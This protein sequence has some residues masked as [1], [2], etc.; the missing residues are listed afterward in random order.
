MIGRICQGLVAAGLVLLS[1]ITIESYARWMGDYRHNEVAYI[2]VPTIVW[3]MPFL[4]II[5]AML[6]LVLFVHLVYSWFGL[7]ITTKRH[8]QE[9]GRAIENLHST[10]GNAEREERR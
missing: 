10:I 1:T 6:G 9:V 3:W 2:D 8:L 4:I 5:G 7:A